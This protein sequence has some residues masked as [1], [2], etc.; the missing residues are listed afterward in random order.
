MAKRYT[1]DAG[2]AQGG[3]Q[4]GKPK[5][6]RAPTKPKHQGYD[7]VDPQGG[8]LAKAALKGIGKA[9]GAASRYLDEKK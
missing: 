2:D 8:K 1:Y 9:F 3:E 7:Y 4:L 6:V 5:I